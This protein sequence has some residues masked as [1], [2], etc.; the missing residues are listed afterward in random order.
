MFKNTIARSLL[1]LGFLCAVAAWL[2]TTPVKAFNYDCPSIAAACGQMCGSSVSWAYQYS[3]CHEWQP[4]NPPVCV[5]WW[6]E[7][8]YSYGSGVQ[9]FECDEYSG[10]S[11]CQCA[12]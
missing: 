2:S 1:Q 10:S 6:H 4:G 3:E 9:Y 7:Y 11:Y 12:Y 8:N 5:D